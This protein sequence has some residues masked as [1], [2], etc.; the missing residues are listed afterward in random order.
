MRRPEL[1]SARWAAGSFAGDTERVRC[2]DVG[3]A[4]GGDVNPKLLLGLVVA[5]FVAIYARTF[6]Y[7]YVWDDV[8]HI[9]ENPIYDG[10]VLDG[11][12]ATQ[13]DHMDPN[14]RNL[15]GIEPAHDSYRPLL[16]LSH[17]MNVALF[18]PNPGSQ[19]VHNVLLGVLAILVFYAVALAW[20]GSATPALTSTAIFALH[21]LQVESIAYISARADL[22]AG[23]FA[24]VAT[25]SAV[26]YGRARADTP[27]SRLVSAGW[28][29][30]AAA[31]FLASLLC[32]EAYIGLPFALVAV[33]AALDQLRLQRALLATLLAVLIAYLGLRSWVA[34]AGTGVSV[35]EALLALPGIW[36]NYL[37]IALA[38]FDL[39]TERLYDS[40]LSIPGWIAVAVCGA[41]TI[42]SLRK[43]S[44]HPFRTPLSGLFWMLTL[45]GPSAFIVLLMGV[46]ADRY[47]YL[48]LGGFAIAAG[49]LLHVAPLRATLRLA[50]R[51]LFAVL[52]SMWLIT[53]VLQ[54][55][56]WKDNRTLYTHAVSTSPESSNAHYR[57]GYYFADRA[58]WST[59]LPLFERAVE[60]DPA[61]H[62][63][64]NNLGV[65]YMNLDR[66]PDAEG[67]FEQALAATQQTH[68]RTWYNLAVV[69]M[70]MENDERACHDLERSRA[71]NPDYD[72]AGQLWKMRCERDPHAR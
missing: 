23:L 31:F 37:S 44:W 3:C 68:F 71:I 17:R 21:P 36:L 69:H 16:F 45:L 12:L 8:S 43:P 35:S 26:Y 57:L 64:L 55:P 56:V 42:L 27:K 60:L 38:P 29:V 63:A 1:R 70:R 48:P 66:L 11:L 15:S 4:W 2:A 62:R 72:K 6:V 65:C 13:H 14:L 20:F 28:I 58:D 59:A 10:P 30:G 49:W 50:S 47:A 34:G 53:T 67:A 61:N 9:A 5:A 52:G 32:K 7:G 24:L 41:F 18:G 39:S 40:G 46:V 51:I 19:H 54:V 22:L 33:F 25:L